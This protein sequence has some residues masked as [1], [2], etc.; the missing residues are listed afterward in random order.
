MAEGNLAFLQNHLW[1][2]PT[3]ETRGTLYH[4][5]RDGEHDRVQLLDAYAH[6][7][8]GTVELYEATLDPN[9]LTF[10]VQLAEALIERFYDAAGGGFWQSG[11]DTPHLLMRVKEDYDGAEPSGNAVAS[12]ALLRLSTLC[13]RPDWREAAEKTLRLFAQKLHQTPQVVPF[14]LCALDFALQEPKRVVV[15]GDWL[16]GSTRAL[17]SHAHAVFEPH[18]VI[19]GNHGPVDPFA[20]TLPGDE[21]RSLAYLCTGNACQ[22]P[23]REGSGVREFLRQAPPPESPY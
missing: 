14:L 16:C 1:V 10:A 12:L 20:R 6:L 11:A 4:R 7:L 18:R 17:L 21:E 5:W 22:P 3:P 13:A 8:A 9:H 19:L 2:P 15:V 23:T